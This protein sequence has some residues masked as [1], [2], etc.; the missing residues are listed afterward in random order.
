[1]QTSRNPGLFAIAIGVAL[2]ILFALLGFT[3]V[4][5]GG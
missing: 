4:L 1:M 5:E 2:A 3:G